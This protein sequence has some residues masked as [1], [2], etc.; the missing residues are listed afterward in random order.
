MQI[1][2]PRTWTWWSRVLGRE[3][4]NS[5]ILSQ[6]LDCPRGPDESNYQL[7][8]SESNFRKANIIIQ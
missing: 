3:R 6:D 7:K 1:R 2:D 8:M 5:F 4:M